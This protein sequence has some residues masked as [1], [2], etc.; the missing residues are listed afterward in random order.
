MIVLPIS[1]LANWT[2]SNSDN[3]FSLISQ[4]QVSFP[5]WN[6]PLLLQSDVYHLILNAH[7]PPPTTP[8]IQLQ[9][10]TSPG[11]DWRYPCGINTI[12]TSNALGHLCSCK[13]G[14]IGDAKGGQDCHPA[15]AGMLKTIGGR[16]LFP[17]SYD[18]QLE[19]K[20]STLYAI[21]VYD[22]SKFIDQIFGYSGMKGY[23]SGSVKIT[24]IR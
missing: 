1:E 4:V 9:R 10:C 22:S 5:G 13:V 15:Q 20:Q 24:Q 16:V 19:D 6:M 21:A 14:H 8:N 18:A 11:S 7:N 23:A 17:K 3:F 12:C 2:S